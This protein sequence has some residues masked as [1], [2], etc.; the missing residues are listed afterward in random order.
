MK[1][2]LLISLLVVPFVFAATDAKDDLI[3]LDK[4]W[5]V[6]SLKGD[7]ATLAKV[8]ADGVF[9]VGPEG[10]FGKADILENAE[11][12]SDNT[13]YT[14]S[15][16]KIEMLGDDVA[17]M[18]HSAGNHRSLHVFQ[19]QAGSWKVIASAAIPMASSSSDD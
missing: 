1:K 13:N 4:E 11:P 5:G 15:D 8:Y 17:V 7:K 18:A 2:L 9:S 3:K 16:Y 6:A 14:T 12:S 10:V 19:K